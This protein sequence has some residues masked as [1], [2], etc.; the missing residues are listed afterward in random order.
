[1]SMG[2]ARSGDGIDPDF[3][4]FGSDFDRIDD[5]L[6]GDNGPAKLL[7]EA[8]TTVV[9]DF[10][11][12]E[13][14]KDVAPEVISSLEETLE[15]PVSDEEMVDAIK[16]GGEHGDGEFYERILNLAIEAD[17]SGDT[18]AI[19][20]SIFEDKVEVS[21]AFAIDY[22]LRGGKRLRPF[23]T[24]LAEFG[25][26]GETSYKGA[27]V[28][29]SQE[30]VHASSLEH[31]DDMDDDVVRRGKLTSERVNKALYGE[32]SWKQSVLDGNKV[33]AWGNEAINSIIDDPSESFDGI[34]KQA[35]K[36]IFQME[37]DL[38]DGQKRDIDMEDMQ[39]GEASL[40]DYEEMIAGKTGALFKSGVDI[41]LEDHLRDS[42]Y[43]QDEREEIRGLFN[44]YMTSFNRLFQSGD[45]AIEV[46]RPEESGKSETDV[47]NRKITFP[48]IQTKDHL[49]QERD[50]YA[51]LL[52]DVFD[53]AYDEVTSEMQSTAEEMHQEA[54]QKDEVREEV[55]ED[56]EDMDL[57]ISDD[58]EAGGEW[59]EEWITNAIR[60]YG[61]EASEAVADSYL[62]TAF[63]AVDELYEMDVINDAARE[64]YKQMAEFVWNR[65]H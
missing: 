19:Q 24:L 63:S 32:G 46:F 23:M 28:G 16:H 38:N 33:E 27:M 6:E 29:A 42:D 62:G 20:N 43:L 57:T 4:S 61:K 36:L 18:H 1:M 30:I 17:N 3:G 49:Q 9:D 39:L 2:E 37:A 22:I 41:I 65:D 15:R 25:L 5:V 40:E 55:F 8:K 44:E 60:M 21:D 54:M 53:G 52:L 31:D 51:E 10:I 12:S 58:A 50:E 56:P 48:A 11:Y 45:D 35:S 13:V 47:A 14:L 34:P 26:E 7:V 64:K 59:E